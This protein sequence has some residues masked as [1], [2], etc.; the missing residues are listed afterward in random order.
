VFIILLLNFALASDP[1]YTLID[2]EGKIIE[3]KKPDEGRYL[4]S[5]S[6]IYS[7]YY[8]LSILGADFRFETNLAHT[9]KIKNG[10][11]KGDLYLIG[12]GDPYLTTAHLTSMV[13][14][15]S[16]KGIKKIE[17]SFYYDDSLLPFTQRLD[18]IGLED[19]T[20]NP[21]MSALNVEF[22]RFRKVGKHRLPPTEN[23]SLK[24]AKLNS[25]GLKFKNNGDDSWSYSTEEKLKWL[26]EVPS[27]NSSK[28]TAEFFRYL[29]RVNG[30][31]LSEPKF[32]KA[33]NFEVITRIKS[34]PLL[35]IA[36]LSME[37]SNNLMAEM[38]MLMA[39]KQIWKSKLKWEL[40]GNIMKK[41]LIEL[42]P[43]NDWKMALFC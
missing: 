6:K 40:V 11:L 32:R 5:I 27:R 13:H 34:L 26:E 9:G 23:M 35:R 4:A 7:L 22:N 20:D 15:L 37:Y 31:A 43:N 24:P 36:E 3:K 16:N 1:S 10:I 2:L 39:S 38:P 8:S 28:Y 17:G 30:I 19:Q 29:A 42:H 25:P 21:S 14:S 33:N 12:G 41:K 18:P